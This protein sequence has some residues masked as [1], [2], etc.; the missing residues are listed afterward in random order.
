MSRRREIVG[1]GPQH[2]KQGK[3]GDWRIKIERTKGSRDVDIPV[4]QE[5]L[6]AAQAMPV[7]G[8][9]YVTGANGQPIGKRTLGVY[10]RQWATEAGLPKRCRLHGLKKSGMTAIVLAGG[11][12]P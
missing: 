12:A 3:D 9:A 10:F 4:T 5:L 7:T 2:L 6:R 1:L 11:T 8:L